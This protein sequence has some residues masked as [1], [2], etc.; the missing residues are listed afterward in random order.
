MCLQKDEAEIRELLLKA[1][2]KPQQRKHLQN[3][4]VDIKRKQ[5]QTGRASLEVKV[6]GGQTAP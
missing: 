5:Q 6:V 3:L 2:N 1:K 4:L